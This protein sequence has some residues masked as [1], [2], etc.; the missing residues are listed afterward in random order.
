SQRNDFAEHVLEHIAERVPVLRDAHW[1]ELL[2]RLRGPVSKATF[3]RSTRRAL[4]RLFDAMHAERARGP[5]DTGR[6]SAHDT[7]ATRSYQFSA[8]ELDLW[9][10]V[11]VAMHERYA[12]FDINGQPIPI[13]VSIPR[14]GKMLRRDGEPPI[15]IVTAV[16]QHARVLISAPIGGG[17]TT[18]AAQMVTAL[19]E[20]DHTRLTVL[21]SLAKHGAAMV[22]HGALSAIVCELCRLIEA[23]DVVPLETLVAKLIQHDALN[24]VLDD[25][26]LMN[27]DP[28]WMRE[29]LAACQHYV[30]LTH[31]SLAPVQPAVD[32]QLALLPL[33]SSELTRWLY[34]VKRYAECLFSQ[35]QLRLVLD[36]FARE[37][38]ADLR[39]SG[40]LLLAIALGLGAEGHHH[41]PMAALL[42][43]WIGHCLSKVPLPAEA[44]VVDRGVTR[45]WLGQ[46]ALWMT[47]GAPVVMKQRK[48]PAVWRVP[49]TALEPPL[50]PHQACDCSFGSP[51]ARRANSRRSNRRLVACS[52]PAHRWIWI[53]YCFYA[54]CSPTARRVPR[55]RLGIKQRANSLNRNCWRYGGPVRWSL[56][57]SPSREHSHV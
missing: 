20:Q 26:D 28:L 9:H 11:T 52:S 6:N 51:R 35:R 45:E 25:C 40:P 8:S 49:S 4:T 48:A 55:S 34:D 44:S 47:W 7:V 37:D 50:L 42:W 19:A 5:A 27:V 39:G 18:L 14:R 38:I 54:R 41:I 17:L 32:V 31:A 29:A 21:L 2:N 53:G 23:E 15:D 3:E 24:L 56:S 13:A 57:K 36:L 10:R 46:L 30:C 12:Q 33:N 16:Q 1:P 22:Q 43:H